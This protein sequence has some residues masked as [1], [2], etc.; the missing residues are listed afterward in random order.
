MGDQ[1]ILIS[2]VL[3]EAN[4]RRGA[5]YPVANAA[6]LARLQAGVLEELVQ[7]EL[8]VQKAKDEK[9]E[10]NDTELQKSLDENEQKIRAQFRTD[11]EFR[12]ALVGYLEWGT[13][14]A[15]HNSGDASDVVAHAP[16]PRWGWGVAPPYQP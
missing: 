8:L 10:S 14:L 13:R 9:V 7:V 4:R 5:G 12:A 1:V 15:M 3:A 2:E 6:D 11:A 16:V